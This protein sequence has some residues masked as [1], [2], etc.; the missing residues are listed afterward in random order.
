[1]EVAWEAL[2]AQTQA[3]RLLAQAQLDRGLTQMA[4]EVGASALVLL[5]LSNSSELAPGWMEVRVSLV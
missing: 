5:A 1:M 3:N 4:P 2:L